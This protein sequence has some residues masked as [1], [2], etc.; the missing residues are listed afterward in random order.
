M[1]N[2]SCIFYPARIVTGSKSAERLMA[3]EIAHQWFGNSVSEAN[4]HHIWLSEGFA[5]YLEN[6][7][8]ENAHGRERFVLKMKA[9]RQRV[10]TYRKA[11]LSPLVDEGVTDYMRLLNVNSYQKGSWVLHM[12]RRRVGEEKFGECLRQFYA[13]YKFGNATSDNFRTVVEDVSGQDL[14]TFFDQWVYSAGHPKLEMDWSYNEESRKLTLNLRQRQKTPVFHFPIE[15]SFVGN[16]ANGATRQRFEVK[17]A[18]SKFEIEL[19]ARPTKVVLDPD[20]WLLYESRSKEK[21]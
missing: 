6:L 20:T 15:V 1:E 19:P 3:H 21:S 7:Y 18:K 2:A 11:F 12:L 8:L 17:Q 13:K 10:V 5:T 14:K 9:N 4:W 16:K